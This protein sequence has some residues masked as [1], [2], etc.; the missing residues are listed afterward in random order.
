MNNTA[1]IVSSPGELEHQDT[2]Q[3]IFQGG[4]FMER[5][6]VRKLRNKLIKAR[7]KA[8]AQAEADADPLAMATVPVDR[9]RMV[10]AQLG[11]ALDRKGWKRCSIRA[12]SLEHFNKFG[13]SIGGI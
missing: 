4:L 13:I 9:Y 6:D 1:V 3:K 11:G 5:S 2:V 7:A 10:I 12:T 8:L